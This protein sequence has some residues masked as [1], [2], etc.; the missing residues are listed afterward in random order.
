MI[1]KKHKKVCTTVNYIQHFL[2]LGCTV[3]GCV[4]ISAFASLVGIPIGITS[5]AIGLKICAI[6]AAIKKV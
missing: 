2:I 6:T 5:S 4:S 1:S 3:T